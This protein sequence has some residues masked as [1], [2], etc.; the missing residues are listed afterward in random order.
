MKKTALLLT[1][2]LVHPLAAQ[3]SKPAG[4]QVERNA[5]VA[6]LVG[7]VAPDHMQRYLTKLVGFGTRH[8]LSDTVSNT[9]GI[10]AARRYI[11]EQYQQMSKAC[12]GCLDVYYDSH[13]VSA[14]RTNNQPV[15][16]VNVVAKLKG[17]TDP[18]RVIVMMGHYDSCQCNIRGGDP[19]GD[20]PGANDDGSGTVEMMELARV[21]SQ[22]FPQGLDATVMFVTVA[23][24]EQGLLGATG[25]ADTLLGDPALHVQAAFTND[26]AGNI[27]DPKGRADSLTMRVFG[28][29]PDDG[30][31]RNLARFVKAVGETYQPNFQV[32]VIERLD[33]MGRGGDHRPFWDRGVAAVR[34]SESFEDHRHQH[35]PEDKLEFVSFP[36]MQK[37]ARVNAATAAHLA[38]A[39]AAPDSLRIR[40]NTQ[41]SGHDFTLSWKAPAN[42][43]DLAGYEI[44]LRSTTSPYV[45]R[46]I[47]VG[48]VTTYKL[49]NTQAD[50]MWVGVRS[51]DKD[52][53]RS[54]VASF[55]SP[56]SLPR[57]MTERRQGR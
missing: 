43:P 53:F 19:A 45:D 49:E 40:R 8:T 11:Y 5:Q 18:N 26:V 15:N 29:E 7:A 38:L 37:I 22:K 3:Q 21:F 6:D 27:Y 35:Y 48:N 46:V 36:Y 9:R 23:G 31:S 20:A 54:P 10:G 50:D 28:P 32:R 24:E 41:V 12:G 4:L 52:G 14:P 57:Y 34:F 2:L 55:H 39:P 16:V 47:P 1:V 42:A 51:V 13:I 33:R 56:E 44:T 17:R 25:L 30:A